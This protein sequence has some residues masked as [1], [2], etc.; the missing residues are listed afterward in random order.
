M[1]ETETETTTVV[2]MTMKPRTKLPQMSPT[3]R[4]SNRSWN[5]CSET[6]FI[7]KV[8]P[9]RGPWNDSTAM[10]SVGP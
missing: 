4:C 2:T 1:T 3:A 8:S 6:P 5:Q 7:A 10:V 9:P